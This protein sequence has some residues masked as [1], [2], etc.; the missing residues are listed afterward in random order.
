MRV[1]LPQQ[2]LAEAAKWAARQL[3]TKPLN[4]VFVGLLLAAAGDQVTLS[5]FDG[6]TS[7]HATL[8][9]DVA[10]A[11]SVVLSARLFADITGSLGKTDVTIAADDTDAQVETRSARFDLAAL[12]LADYPT[13]PVAPATTG[14][15][16]GAEL[17]TAV[18]KVKAAVARTG[19][20]SFAGMTGIRLKVVGDRLELTA[21]DRYR[22]ARHTIP[23]QAADGGSDAM[24]VV[25]GHVMVANAKAFAG[26]TVHLALPAG[27]AGTVGFDTGRRRVT[28]M[29]IEPGLFPHKLDGLNRTSQATALF[30]TEDLTHAIKQV[31]TVNDGDKPIWIAFD[32]RQGSVRARDTGSAQVRFDADFEGDLDDIDAAFNSQWLLDGLDGLTGRIAFEVNT[33]QTP[34]V[35]HDPDDDTY[36]YLV[37]PIRDPHKAAA[38]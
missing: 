23:W 19:E 8:D 35:L 28:T 32:G 4:P 9:A 17:A 14:S 18:A 6:E 7:I 15:V 16:D 22:I 31:T 36:S 37:I 20:G 5:A 27:G 1:T 38:P 12:P 30:D 34:A 24:A 33:P 21:T 25:P 2:E 3:P 26:R 29:L 13:L 10:E 11:G